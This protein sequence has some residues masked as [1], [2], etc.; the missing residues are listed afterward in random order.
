MLLGT[1]WSHT[2]RYPNTSTAIKNGI[3]KTKIK[4][5]YVNIRPTFLIILEFLKFVPKNLDDFRTIPAKKK[6]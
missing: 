3:T 1:N 5:T 2:D 4:K 6:I